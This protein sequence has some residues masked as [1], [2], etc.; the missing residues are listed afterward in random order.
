MQP[1][2]QL[3]LMRD[4]EVAARMLHAAENA[5]CR[6]LVLTVDTQVLGVRRRDARSGINDSTAWGKLRRGGQIAARPGWAMRMARTGLPITLGNISTALGGNVSF[7]DCMAYTANGLERQF[8]SAALR[9]LR[10]KWPHNLV[11][12]GLTE[13]E[14]AKLAIA[15][16]V[17]GI[18]VSN[19]GG[20]QLDGVRSSIRSLVAIKQATQDRIPLVLDS[21]VRSGIDVIKAL[22]LGAEG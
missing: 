16:G 21:G 1:W 10:D 17:D 22:A 13:P 4:R 7:A 12:K 18:I 9:W 3:Y 5:G 8:D 15:H 11:I 20:R 2:F 14:D 6:T 19:H